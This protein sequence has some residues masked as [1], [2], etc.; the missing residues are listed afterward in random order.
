MSV[1]EGVE[2]GTATAAA[3]STIGASKTGSDTAA[4]AETRLTTSRRSGQRRSM[5]L[6]RLATGTQHDAFPRE[7]ATGAVPM[8]AA[9]IR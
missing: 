5:C 7:F 4:R 2:I 3:A 9:A 1:G 6:P 8:H